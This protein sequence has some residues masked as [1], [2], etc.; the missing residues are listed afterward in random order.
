[1]W[2]LNCKNILK[3]T[4]PTKPSLHVVSQQIFVMIKKDCSIK[5]WYKIPLDPVPRSVL[6]VLF[7]ILRWQMHVVLWCYNNFRVHCFMHLHFAGLYKILCIVQYC[8]N[9]LAWP[10]WYIGDNVWGYTYIGAI[11]LNPLF[12]DNFYITHTISLTTN[13]QP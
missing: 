9:C 11:L 12:I 1:M 2:I 6:L 5:F 3:T 4:D 7:G 13:Y 8:T 10:N